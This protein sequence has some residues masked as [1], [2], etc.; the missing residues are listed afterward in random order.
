[1]VRMFALVV[2]TRDETE[3]DSVD[4]EQVVDAVF[5]AFDEKNLVSVAGRDD[6]NHD[7]VSILAR[8]THYRGGGR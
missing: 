1:M 7:T 6:T 4:I 8:P 3:P 5:D 2:E